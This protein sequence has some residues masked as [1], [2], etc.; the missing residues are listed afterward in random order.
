MAAD[1]C[2]RLRGSDLNESVSCSP[3]TAKRPYLVLD[4]RIRVALLPQEEQL[5]SVEDECFLALRSTE[6]VDVRHQSDL[7]RW[8]AF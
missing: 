5:S 4:K 6:T 8:F 1:V 3:F 2:E 7:F